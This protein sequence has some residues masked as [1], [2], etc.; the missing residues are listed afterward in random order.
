MR[1]SMVR[2][3]RKP[4]AV[5]TSV[6][7][8]A[9]GAGILRI[10]SLHSHQ[11]PPGEPA[12]ISVDWTAAAER[13]GALV[14]L[15]TISWG[16]ASRRDHKA[17]DAIAPL[18]RSS[19][20][21]VHQRLTMESIG[22]WSLLYTWKGTR[23][24]LPPIILCAHLD[25]VPAE[26]D[27]DSPWTHPP[28]DG[29]IA[30]GSI[31]GRGT[32]DDKGAVAGLFEATEALLS[33]G[34]NPARTVYFAFGHNEEGGG[35]S[36]GARSIAATLYARGVRNAWLMDEGGLIANAVPGV[37]RPVAFVGV[38][39]KGLLN[40]AIIAR[41]SGGHS[42]MPPDQTAV[43]ILA[44][45]IDRLE[46][47]QMPARLDGA[48]EAMFD[49]LVPDMSFGMR[50]ALANL[51]LM[52]P[53]VIRLLAMKPQT[54]ALVRTTTAPTMLEGSSKVNVLALTATAVVNFRL[55]PGDTASVVEA[56]VQRTI[57]DSRVE[58]KRTEPAREASSASPSDTPQFRALARS[59]RAIYP[60]VLVAPYLTVGITDA[61]EYTAVA[62]GLYRFLPIYQEGALESIHG[63][64]EHVTIEAYRQAIR[65]YATIITELT[66]D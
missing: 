56:H 62:S 53:L 45:A 37:T 27:S 6:L 21:L 5:V 15:P 17:F 66:R 32:I 26:A 60:N 34:F 58:L 61:R 22:R 28:F 3:L 41:S 31:W 63:V 20:P 43:G 42:A 35:D 16:D 11:P 48:A 57:A 25:V 18:L 2:L 33:S 46:R 52:R 30:G 59:I 8:L 51:W 39:E 1:I 24:D 12:P 54:N 47:N 29:V 14:R 64:N 65:T 23:P 50:A 40:L 55:L 7:A 49:T 38:A 10:V 36:N 44:R 9:I 19:F 13:L 4:V